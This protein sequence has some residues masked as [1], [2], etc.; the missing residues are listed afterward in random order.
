MVWNYNVGILLFSS[1]NITKYSFNLDFAIIIVFH[2]IFCRNSST[3]L[4]NVSVNTNYIKVYTNYDNVYTN[5]Y[6]LHNY[7]SARTT[8]RKVLRIFQAKNKLLLCYTPNY[9][10]H[11]PLEFLLINN[12]FLFFATVG[13]PPSLET[14]WF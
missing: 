4:V 2:I 5:Y 8:L 9:C 10:I 14:S 3:L 1:R 6:Y 13:H 12:W 11:S 7:T